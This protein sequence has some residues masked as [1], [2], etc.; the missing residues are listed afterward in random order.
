LDFAVSK[1]QI[2]GNDKSINIC[3][4]LL[5]LSSEQSLDFVVDKIKIFAN[6]KKN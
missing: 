2:F 1:T 4:Y 3:R 5:I 6:N